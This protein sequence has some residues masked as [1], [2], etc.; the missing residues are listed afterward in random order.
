MTFDI[1]CPWS[2]GTAQA[3]KVISFVMDIILHVGAHRTAST[4]FQR[5][6]RNN[7]TE[8]NGRKI[9]FWGP[10]RL[11]KGLFAGLYPNPAAANRRNL[12]RRAEGRVRMHA[13]MTRDAGADQLIVSEENMIGAPRDC[14]RRKSLYPA[15]GER[16]ARVSAAFDGQV[17]RVVLSIRSQELWWSSVAA[18]A[19]ARG[20]DIPGIL[21]LDKIAESRRS[22][23]DVITDLSCAVPGAD[24][25]VL[26]FEQY[27]GRPDAAFSQA[28]DRQAPSGGASTWLNRSPDLADLRQM[29]DSRGQNPDK[30]P[31]GDG[32][33]TPFLPDQAAALRETYFDDIMWLTAGADGLARLTKED[34]RQRSGTSLTSGVMKK[35]QQNDHG[36]EQ[37][38]RSG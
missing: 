10:R 24:I 28:T 7:L 21:T 32:R 13:E 23:R 29:L 33:W 30:L 31:Q 6:I 38:A 14:L 5:Y 22:W 11:R 2:P 17:S 4:S 8:L 36:Q 1:P 12:Q 18:F 26:P 3:R 27:A 15:V 19:V 9:A 37:L 25:V 34:T 35:G 20:H 16:M